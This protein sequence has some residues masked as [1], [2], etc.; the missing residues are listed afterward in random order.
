MMD[1]SKNNVFELIKGS[2]SDEA[3]DDIYF[4]DTENDNIKTLCVGCIRVG[5]IEVEQKNYDD[6]SCGNVKVSF[7]FYIKEDEQKYEYFM[8]KFIGLCKS[9][10]QKENYW[11]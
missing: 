8:H 3:I 6:P 2:L 5:E 11:K 10:Q 7:N 4:E 1:F 9:L